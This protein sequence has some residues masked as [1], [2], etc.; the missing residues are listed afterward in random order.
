MDFGLVRHVG[1]VE[2]T[3]VPDRAPVVPAAD[4]SKALDSTVDV[5]QA[6]AT[7]TSAEGSADSQDRLTETGVLMGTPAYMSP[8][9]FRGKVVDARSDQFSF[10]VALYEALYGLRPFEGPTVTALAINVLSGQIIPPPERSPVPV[11]IWQALRRG[12]SIDPAGR[13]PSMNELLAD[14]GRAPEPAPAK[15]PS[16]G[17][18]VSAAHLASLLETLLGRPVQA[19]QLDDKVALGRGA[20]A[21]Y[22]AADGVA[23]ALV[24][25]DLSAAA[26]IAAALTAVPPE[27]VAL[28]IS[29]GKLPQNLTDNLLEVANV[30]TALVRGTGSA[31][32]RI[33]QVYPLPGGVPPIIRAALAGPPHAVGFDVSVADYPGGQVTVVGLKTKTPAISR[34]QTIPLR[35]ALVVDDSGAMRLVIGRAL[36]RLGVTQILE[37]SNGQLGLK[38]LHQEAA[39]EAV[40]VDWS[41]PVMDGLTFIKAVRAE[42]RFDRVRLV[43]VT[44]EGDPAQIEAAM[45]AGADEYLIKPISD[46]LLRNKLKGIGLETT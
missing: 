22:A 28:A 45:A 43:M 14:L 41:M 4:H 9:Q 2:A 29:A 18:A 1:A 35:G 40:F 33:Q 37:A 25:F 34:E 38:T 44:T 31:R 16:E 6:G 17:A 3:T 10:C 11:M 20:V 32:L 19:R 23:A 26:G 46:Q 42:R 5:A 13:Y 39:V 8:E 27:A 30:L 21:S 36:A 12:L 15:A 24:H 7:R